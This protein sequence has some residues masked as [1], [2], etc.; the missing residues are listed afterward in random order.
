[1][2][3]RSGAKTSVLLKQAQG[4]ILHQWTVAETVLPRSWKIGHPER[5]NCFAQ[6]SG[7]GVEGPLPVK[8]ADVR[9][10][11]FH[12]RANEFSATAHQPLAIRT[13]MTRDLGQPCF[14]LGS[15]KDFHALQC[16]RRLHALN[17]PVAYV[18]PVFWDRKSGAAS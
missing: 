11:I 9:Q 13:G 12:A 17:G 6:R 15:E 10:G 7:C 4:D 18:R 14:L 5:S 16:R 2:C 1:M 3:F 8:F